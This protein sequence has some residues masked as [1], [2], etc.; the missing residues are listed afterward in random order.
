MTLTYSEKVI[1][2]NPLI[3]NFLF[4]Q[5]LSANAFSAPTPAA[6]VDH[7]LQLID[8]GKLPSIFL[9]IDDGAIAPEINELLSSIRGF[10]GKVGSSQ[11]EVS[12]GFNRVICES[13]QVTPRKEVD[14]VEQNPR[15]QQ[16]ILENRERLEEVLGRILQAGGR[17]LIDEATERHQKW[18]DDVIA[19]GEE[20][21]E[22][23]R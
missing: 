23:I 3:T 20:K 4:M 8:E 22:A 2:Y 11:G 6:A 13:R 14:G 17:I 21:K 5:Q 18:L 1:E 7:A 9:K 12:G 15:G 16:V 19:G 10:H